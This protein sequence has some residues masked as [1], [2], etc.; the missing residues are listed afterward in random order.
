MAARG[1]D[2][3]RGRAAAVP[4]LRPADGPRRPPVPPLE[5]TP[6]RGRRGPDRTAT[7]RW[8]AGC[9][10]RRT[11]RFLVT[12]RADGRRGPGRVQAAAGRAAALGLPR[13]D[14]V[15]PGGRGVRGVPRARLGRRAGH[16]APR[17]TARRATGRCSASSTTTPRS[18]TSPCSPTTRTGSAS[19]RRSTCCVNNADRKGG[20]CL[21][22]LVNDVILGIDHGLDLPPAWKLRTVMWDFAGEPV[23]ARAARRRV[24]GERR[25]H[26]RAARPPPRRR[27]PRPARARRARR[28]G[29]GPGPRAAASPSPTPATTRC[30]GRWSRLS[31]VRRS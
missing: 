2:G 3:R 29:R 13:R 27:A 21:H 25:G 30:R 9:G 26:R 11:A 8:S 7:S 18:T 28:P 1:A 12:A 17:P 22:D 16:G 6:R 31:R 10:T 24:P 19:S 4:A 14:A 20:H 15:P 23:P 5:L